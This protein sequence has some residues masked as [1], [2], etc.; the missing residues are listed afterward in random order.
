MNI[1]RSKTFCSRFNELGNSIN[2]KWIWN[3]LLASYF[4]VNATPLYILIR[5]A[6]KFFLRLTCRLQRTFKYALCLFFRIDAAV[7]Y[8]VSVRR[9]DASSFP[10]SSNSSL[11]FI[12]F[13]TYWCHLHLRFC[14]DIFAMIKNYSAILKIW[15]YLRAPLWAAQQSLSLFVRVWVHLSPL[16]FRSI[17]LLLSNLYSESGLIHLSALDQ[18]QDKIHPTDKKFL[19]S[20]Y[21]W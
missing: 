4:A 12:H 2:Y 9:L 13:A 16:W 8:T 7:R 19:N 3:K 20:R 1:I 17:A 10:F 21:L 18:S 5:T 14:S 11:D 6:S 15:C